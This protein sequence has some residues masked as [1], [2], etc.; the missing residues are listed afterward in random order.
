MKRSLKKELSIRIR[1][2]FDGIFF[3]ETRASLF[4]I[5]N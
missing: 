5:M 3:Y 4:T 2:F 1:I